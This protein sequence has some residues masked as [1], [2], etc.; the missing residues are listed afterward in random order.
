MSFFSIPDNENV[1]IFVKSA[2]NF[3][4]KN[5]DDFMKEY[6][7]TIIN[8]ESN[9]PDVSNVHFTDITFKYYISKYDTFQ[10]NLFSCIKRLFER[11]KIILFK[12]NI[13]Q[14]FFS[15][16]IVFLIIFFK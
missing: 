14:D 15:L 11:C 7:N 5:W 9:M 4:I 3:E 6:E 12:I 10:H 2:T 13:L 1:N 8:S 16:N